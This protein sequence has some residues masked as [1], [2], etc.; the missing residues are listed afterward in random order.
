[1]S[2]VE[3]GDE[4]IPGINPT[5][6][7]KITHEIAPY[8]GDWGKMKTPPNASKGRGNESNLTLV[9]AFLGHQVRESPVY[10]AIPRTQRVAA[11]RQKWLDL[12]IRAALMT[13]FAGL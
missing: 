11:F 8:T 3:K 5:V 10:A 4:W 1:M 6:A 7:E 12:V 9:D 13:T 2:G